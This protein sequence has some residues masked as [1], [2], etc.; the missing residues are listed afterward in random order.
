MHLTNSLLAVSF[1]APERPA[2]LVVMYLATAFWPM[3]PST[4]WWKSFT[5]SPRFQSCVEPPT[6][7]TLYMTTWKKSAWFEQRSLHHCI[8]Q[9]MTSASASDSDGSCLP[10]NRLLASEA[11]VQRVR[12][13]HT[14]AGSSGELAQRGLAPHAQRVAT[15]TLYHTKKGIE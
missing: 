14:A 15:L 2:N 12:R 6:S 13:A 3:P 11:A 5:I 10:G 8:A 9:P 7:L 1:A 4:R